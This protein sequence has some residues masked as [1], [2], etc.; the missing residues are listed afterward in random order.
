MSP[1]CLLLFWLSYRSLFPFSKTTRIFLFKL[2]CFSTMESI[3]SQMY[4]EKGE[5]A[6]ARA[7]MLHVVFFVSEKNVQIQKR[8]NEKF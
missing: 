8:I 5:G 1:T 6:H 3:H 4:C 7:E 2:L